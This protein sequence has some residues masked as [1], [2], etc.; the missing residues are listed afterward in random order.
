ME[1]NKEKQENLK[2]LYLLMYYAPCSHTGTFR[3]LRFS[4]YFGKH[5]FQQF[6][7]TGKYNT[8]I[9]LKLNE[10]IPTDAI[11]YRKKINIAQFKWTNRQNI[12]NTL[13]SKLVFLLKDIFFSPDKYIWWVLAYIPKMIWTIRK[14]K[15]KL[16][17]TSGPCFSLFIGAYLLKK[18]CKVKFILD[19][20]DPWTNGWIQQTQGFIYQ[21]IIS[22]WE[23]RCVCNSD[24]ITTCTT[25]MREY[26]QEKY[27]PKCKILKIP[28]GFDLDE[29]DWGTS[30]KTPI[31]DNIFTFL[32]TGKFNIFD[33]I[34]NPENMLKAYDIFT[35][36]YDIKDSEL[37]FIGAS[38]SETKKYI[39]DIN[40]QYVHIF[41]SMPKQDI[42]Q[43]Q[44]KANV[45]IHF[46]YPVTPKEIVS[47]KIC[48]YA[49]CKKPII[50]FS[51]KEGD[52]YNLIK[53]NHI[54]ETADTHNI[55][56]MVSLYHKAYQGKIEIS[57]N[58][59]E[60]LSDYN[61]EYTSS[62]LAN[63]IARLIKE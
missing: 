63:E 27:H 43:I 21:K 40:N 2:L 36:K 32:Y 28:N 60:Q 51:I 35:R 57:D 23:R 1:M 30:V 7:F 17:M 10:S 62:I 61:V 6:I 20:R 55:E 33:K 5:G 13:C 58:P 46:F 54:G 15:I 29:L 4:K 9:N 37:F 49:I 56:E 39:N 14:E 18:I 24:L 22:F 48:E 25:E 53:N 3:N 34:Y 38:N 45:L 47:L 26:L 16:L 42:I 52:L 59:E 19:Y 50:S 41:D 8:N 12:K 11:I 44:K 31:K